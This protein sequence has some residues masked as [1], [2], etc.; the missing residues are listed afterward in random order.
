MMEK[1]QEHPGK[2]IALTPGVFVV[3]LSPQQVEKGDT[4]QNLC[5]ATPNNIE[6]TI[7]GIGLYLGGME[8]NIGKEE[9]ALGRLENSGI[10]SLFFENPVIQKKW[11]T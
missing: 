3:E 2:L 1:E 6:L 9:P 10:I 11:L 4:P 5:I 8:G 7:Y